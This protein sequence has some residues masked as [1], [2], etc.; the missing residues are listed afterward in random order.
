MSNRPARFLVLRGGAIGDFIVTLPVLQA[1]RNRWPDSYI[2][3]VGYPRVARLSLWGGLANKVDS[4]DRAQIA[5]FFS[6]KPAFTLEQIAHVRS[7]DIIFLYLN[8]P[9]G[10]VRENLALAGARHVVYGSPI[11]TSGHAVD[12]LLKPLESLAMYEA[13]ACPQLSLDATARDRA[14]ALLRTA[15]FDRR[16][17]I[18]HPGSGSPAKNWPT[19][20][21]VEVGAF[22]GERGHRVAWLC[23]EADA[24]G[25]RRLS[26]ISPH[27]VVIEPPTVEEAAGALGCAAGFVGNDSGITHIAAALGVPAVAIFGASDPAVWGPRGPRVRIVAG[28]G[29]SMANV[30]A[31]VVRRMIVDILADQV[32]ELVL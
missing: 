15:G 24:D 30:D 17:W 23:G 12:H 2:E 6:R 8:D 29:G 7:F 31:S 3:V 32:E 13:G 1:V 19:E 10:L 14:K 22:L 18:L 4:L 28:E 9:D 11:V 27:A 16:P 25:K 20:R 26:G 21:F 5:T